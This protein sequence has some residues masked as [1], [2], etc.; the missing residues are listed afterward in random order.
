[1]SLLENNNWAQAFISPVGRLLSQKQ[2]EKMN[3]FVVVCPAVICLGLL[4]GIFFG[5]NFPEIR[6]NTVFTPANCTVIQKQVVPYRYCYKSCPGCY[7]YYG[8]RSCSSAQ[9]QNAM[10]SKYDLSVIP[11]VRYNITLS[12]RKS[13]SLPSPSAGG[14]MRQWI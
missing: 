9:S 1:M 11:S 6:K 5:L 8:S 3:V 7:T 12:F 10:Y 14:L 13:H 4:L 2:V